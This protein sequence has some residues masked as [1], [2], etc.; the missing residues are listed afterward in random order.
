[1]HWPSSSASRESTPSSSPRPCS[2]PTS[3]AGLAA[4]L[5]AG[6]NWD[7]VDIAEEGGESR[8]QAARAR[9]HGLR[10][11]RLDERAA[12]RALP[13]RH[14]RP[15]RVRRRGAGRGARA[16]LRGLLDRSDDDR[17][18][19]RRGR[20]PVDRG[21]R[22]DRRGR[23]RPRRAGE[24]L[25]RRGARQGARRRGRRDA[26]GRRRG[27]V[28]VRDAGRPDREDG[29]AEALRRLRDLGRD[30][31][32]GRHAGLGHR[33]RDQQGPERADLRVLRPREWSATCTRSSRS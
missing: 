16:E 24:L 3:P 7:L 15:G 14:V 22:R 1:M 31:A 25:A 29:L 23:P 33:G 27:L 21:R 19:A 13:A 17:A 11:R 8:R 26:R 32:Q 12:A 6:L 5:D 30:P 9:G 20:G 10:R 2:R 18:G 28:P 4:R